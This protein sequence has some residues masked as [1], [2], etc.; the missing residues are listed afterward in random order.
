M[1]RAEAEPVASGPPSSQ[2][3]AL[4]RLVE[5]ESFRALALAAIVANALLMGLETSPA[6]QRVQPSGS[7]W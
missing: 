7:T 2:R 1:E 4:A 6:P 5:S 3:G